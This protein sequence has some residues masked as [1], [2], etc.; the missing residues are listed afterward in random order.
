MRF[1]SGRCSVLGAVMLAIAVWVG[2]VPTA[3]ALDWPEWLGAERDGVW[4]ETGLVDKFPPGG[5]NA[6]WRVPIGAG[7]SGPAVADGRVYVMDRQRALDADRKPKRATRAGVPGSERVL[8]LD[9]ESG[10]L[11]WKDEYDRPYKIS[12]GSGPRTTPLVRAGRVYTLG[13]MGDLRC[14]DAVIGKLVW[15]RNL[16]KD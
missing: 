7:Y 6:L 15:A 2:A 16:A 9:A 13:A 10:K 12:Y 11:L 4:R 3:R 5:P 8:C 1:T 14:L